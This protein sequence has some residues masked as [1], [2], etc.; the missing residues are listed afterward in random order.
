M[1]TV[2]TVSAAIPVFNRSHCILQAVDSV[3][4][5]SL[6]VSELVIVDD[7]STDDLSAALAQVADRLRVV[8]HPKTLGAAAARNTA[9]REARGDLIAFLDSDDTW[10]PEKLERQI[11]FMRARDL[12]FSCTGFEIVEPGGTS[13]RPAWRPYPEVLHFDDF[14]WGCFVAP[15]STFIAR[16]DLLQACGGY[17]TGFP[18]FEDWDLMLRVA[19]ANPKGVGFLNEPLATIHS[20]VRPQSDQVLLSLDRMQERHLDPVS[21]KDRQLARNLRSG[22]AFHRASAH[23]ADGN[24]GATTSEL[25]RCFFLAPLGNFPLRVILGGKFQKKLGRAARPAEAAP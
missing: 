15:G 20:G 17:D 16:R 7:G 12:D 22:I 18:R 8:R 13:A 23:A 21:K 14:V 10:K 1:S 2:P 24:W 4:R 19:E 11:A 5:Q 9:I 6:P 3:L 25:A